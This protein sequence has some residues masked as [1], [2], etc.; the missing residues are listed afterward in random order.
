MKPTFL[1]IIHVYQ[2]EG[3][4]ALGKM[5]NPATNQLSKNEDHARY[6]VDLLEIIKEKTAGN[7]DAEESRFLDQTLSTLRLN[8]VEV[9]GNP[10]SASNPDQLA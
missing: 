10:N 3:M 9:F 6:V 1:N 2:F 8:F 4:V 5:L 7:L